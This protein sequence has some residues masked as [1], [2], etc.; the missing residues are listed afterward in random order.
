[1]SELGVGRWLF[2]QSQEPTEKD[3]ATCFTREAL[4]NSELPAVQGGTLPKS[5]AVASDFVR[6][7]QIKLA[8]LPSAEKSRMDLFSVSQAAAAP[9]FGIELRP[10]GQR[11]AD[12]KLPSATR[13]RRETDR[14][15]EYQSGN[16][17]LRALPDYQRSS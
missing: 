6:L 13:H 9:V 17:Q 4:I 10:P 11:L 12:R 5:D 8:G 14:R 2:K 15:L 16:T 7:L 3:F 1:M